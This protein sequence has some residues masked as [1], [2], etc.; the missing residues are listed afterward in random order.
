VRRAA[1]RLLSSELYGIG[2]LDGVAYAGAWSVTLVI[3][4]LASYLPARRATRVNPAVT[5]RYE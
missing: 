4:L 1:S 2:M 3:A 5:L